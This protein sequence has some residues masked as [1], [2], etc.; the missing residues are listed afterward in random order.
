MSEPAKGVPEPKESTIKSAT[1]G[2]YEFTFDTDKIDDVEILDTIDA[3]ENQK[4][5]KEIITFLQYLIGADGYEKL[6]AYF[7]NKDGK[8]KLSKLFEVYQAIFEQFDPKG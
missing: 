7:V 5:L 6:K 8:F 3:I 1:V 4:K 2:G